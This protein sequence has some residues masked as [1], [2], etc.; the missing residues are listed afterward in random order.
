VDLQGEE[1]PTA[2]VPEVPTAQVPVA[3]MEAVPTEEQGAAIV[4]RV[5][6]RLARIAQLVVS[7]VE[8]EVLDL[9]H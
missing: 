1:V 3:P 4:E 9:E 7:V 8:E 2:Q 6:C 5:E